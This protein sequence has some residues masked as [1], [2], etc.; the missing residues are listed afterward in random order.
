MRK[1]IYTGA[2]LAMCFS[3]L[4]G[5]VACANKLPYNAVM[6]GEIYEVRTWLK[7]DFYKEN[8]TFGSFSEDLGDYIKDNAYPQYRTKIITDINEFDAVF[9][10][11]PADV[12]FEKTMILMHCFTTSSSGKY[13][14][15]SI[16]VDEKTSIIRY[17]HPSSK[18]KTPPNNSAPLTKWVI[19]TIDKLD[20]ETVEFIFGGN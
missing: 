5:L 12:D 10:E 19:V 2:M 20:I 17:K 3:L 7:D 9:K 18:R 6:Y 15:K 16:S 1:L 8:L 11:F 14:I 13:E 4:A